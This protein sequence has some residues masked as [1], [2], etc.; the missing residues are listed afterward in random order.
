[1]QLDRRKPTHYIKVQDLI[2]GERKINSASTEVLFFGSL[3]AQDELAAIIFR[4]EKEML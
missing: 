4:G 1:M 3:K 2:L